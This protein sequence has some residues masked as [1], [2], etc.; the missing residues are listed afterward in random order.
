[1]PRLREE[2]KEEEEEE[3]GFTRGW[4]KPRRVERE[5][6]VMRRL[7]EGSVKRSSSL[8][9]KKEKQKDRSIEI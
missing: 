2:N 3:E 9:N 7:G 4:Q 8:V 6:R 1:M 5:R